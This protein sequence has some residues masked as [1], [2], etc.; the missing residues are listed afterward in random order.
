M[1]YLSKVDY[2]ILC[3]NVDWNNMQSMS[4]KNFSIRDLNKRLFLPQRDEAVIA[5]FK[6]CKN[7]ESAANCDI[8]TVYRA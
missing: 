8:L 1:G 7:Y 6:S 3:D 4:R 5:K 2:R